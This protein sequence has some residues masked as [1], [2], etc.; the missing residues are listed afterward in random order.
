RFE[1]DWG[2]ALAKARAEKRPLMVDVFATWCGPCKELDAKVFA[3]PEAERGL[4]DFVA[5]KIDGERGD[6][7][8]LVERY[9]VV[10]YPTVLFLDS[11]GRELDR[12][13]GTM[14]AADFIRTA[15]D[16]ARGRGTLEEAE[17]R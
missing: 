3:T 7:P 13:F 10:G 8:K 14:A 2:K 17:E 11:E 4:A 9:H 12:I 15:R 16:F 1:T 5:V 6:G